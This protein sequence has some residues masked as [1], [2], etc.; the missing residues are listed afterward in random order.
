MDTLWQDI[1]FGFRTLLRSP[2]T[3]VVAL[4]TLALGIGANTAIFSVVNGVLLQPLPYPDP[5]ELVIVLESNPG[6][7]F[8]RFSVAPPNFDDWRRQNQVFGSMAAV[9]QGRFNLTGGERPE[10][11]A[12]AQVTPE[13]FP[14]IGVPPAL[15]RGFLPEEGRAGGPKVAV[16]SHGIWQRR[17]GSD[18]GIV[19]RQ[20][21]IDGESFTVIGV[22]PPGFSF[23]S[24]C[25][26]WLPLPWDF[27]PAS[28]GG[29]FLV[30]FGRLKDG[31]TL[32]RARTE[33]K[34][35]A[36]RLERQYPDSNKGW[37]TELRLLQD[38]IVE[39]VRPALLLLLAAVAFVLLIACANVANLLLAR[40]ASRER[41][42]AVRT[43]LGAGRAR[44][45]RQMV[46]ESVVLFLVGGA[47]GLVLATWATRALVAFYGEGLPSQQE[48]GIDS[49]VLFFT[50]VLALVTGIL[51]GLAPAL[52]ATSGG[53]F[54]ALKE[55]GRAVAGGARG[56]LMRNLLVLGEVAVALVLL[57]GAGLLLRSFARLRAVDPGFHPKGVLTAELILPEKK[58]AEQ[59]RQ[60]LFTR[61]LLDRLRAIPGVQSADTVFPMPLGGNGFVLA[62]EVQ[63]R[64]VA[65]SEDSSLHANVRLVTPDFFRTMGIRVLQGRVFT[66][67]DDA[68][69]I[70]VIV[71]NKI[72]A[73][74]IWPG[75]S[76]VGKR[77]T[78]GDSEGPDVQW[79]EV[80]G[81]VA[82]IRHQALD[83]DP[84]SEVYWAQLQNPV[85]GQLS[86]V[87]RTQG[88]PTKLAGAVREAV[89]S[90]DG[91][92]PVERV[93]R[94]ED[95][96]SEALTSSRFQTVLLG[97]F[98]GAALLLAAIGVYGVI[99][100]S[101]AQRTHEIGIRMALGARRPEVL[102]LVVRQGM[103]LVLAGVGV[104]LA[105]SLLLTWWLSERIAGFVY[106]GRAVDPPTLVAVPLMLL[107]VALLA[108]WLPA[109]RA[110]RVEPVV[111]L[112][113][114]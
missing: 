112:R 47:L 102:G 51:F 104:G 65:A 62:F 50:L 25:E 63:G 108:N 77:I 20:I 59:E 2:A 21:P 96:V 83:K 42:I 46:T 10:A 101:V 73:D 32:E 14:T 70:P 9:S 28:R 39:N 93:R 57:V 27:P 37:T 92:L 72:M 76:P 7:G 16:L 75:E 109:L 48:I 18:P 111:A 15:G 81:V 78:F 44:L 64:P 53:L 66:P 71:I 52:S 61:E 26:V 99:S 13:F 12:G 56:R 74:R 67:R 90:I 82:G 45:V 98:A 29:H 34:A 95:V 89:R 54:G 22:M 3:S 106:G 69:S 33:M 114:E 49:R 30:V 107:A 79:M 40:L 105:F 17:F 38:S 8:P 35:I 97:I 4:L 86:V 88:E 55:G 24:K 31:M 91:D 41:E 43:A 60:I 87:L 113:S 5:G 100:Y 19:N 84:G 85:S 36:A 94:M 103:T 110:T 68:K 11:V 23:P 6:L 80:I 1:R 58:Y